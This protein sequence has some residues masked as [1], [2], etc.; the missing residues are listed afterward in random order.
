[1]E[2]AA[3]PPT[4]AAEAPHILFLLSDDFPW[5]IWPRTGN[6]HMRTLLP[7]LHQT[8]VSDGLDLERHYAYPLCAPARASL[9]TGRWPHRAYDTSSM[10]ACKGI[11]PAMSTIADK[12]KRCV[13]ALPCGS[14]HHR[15]PALWPVTPLCAIEADP[16]ACSTRVVSSA[17]YATHFV[18]RA[19]RSTCT[20][21]SRAARPV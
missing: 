19:A 18:V 10:R 6:A 8:F 5:E 21:V 15:G 11:S 13:H 4:D 12:L 14:M 2:A 16:V 17:G 1:M 7:N 20:H 9:L 3:A